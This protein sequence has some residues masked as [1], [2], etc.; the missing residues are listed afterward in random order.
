MYLL[1]LVFDSQNLVSRLEVVIH[2]IFKTFGRIVC[3]D[4]KFRLCLQIVS[5]MIVLEG[6]GAKLTLQWAQALVL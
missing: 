2:K 3:E 4:Y 1:L 6:D 5:L